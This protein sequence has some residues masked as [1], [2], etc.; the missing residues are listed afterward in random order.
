VS[1][2][3]VVTVASYSGSSGTPSL[4]AWRTVGDVSI[5]TTVR[6]SMEFDFTLPANGV[7]RL[8][9]EV[10]SPV[11][12]TPY[13]VF[14]IEVWIDGQFIDRVDLLL[15]YGG[16]GLVRVITPWLAQGTH[17][18]R[19]VYDNTLSYRPIQINALRIQEIGGP[20]ADD[21]GRADWIDARLAADNSLA[22]GSGSGFVSPAFVEGVSRFFDSLAIE[23]DGQPAVAARS[24]GLGWFADVPLVPG[25]LVNLRASFENGALQE[26]RSLRWKPFNLLV[27]PSALPAGRLR[28]RMNDTLL[29]TATPDEASVMESAADPTESATVVISRAGQ[30]DETFILDRPSTAPQAHVF[31]APGIYTITGTHVSTQGGGSTLTGTVEVEVVAAAFSGDPV[32][33]LAN[34]IVWDNPLLPQ[35]VTIEHDQGVELAELPVVTGSS[36]RLLTR[37]LGVSRVVARLHPGG[38]ILDQALVTGLRVVSDNHTAID[39]LQ[40]YPDGSRL[41]GTPIMLS[42]I[43]PDTR[44]E[45]EIFVN[46]VTFEDGTTLKVF[47]A[48][49]FDE[50]GRVYVKFVYPAGLGSSFCHRIHVYRGEKYLGTF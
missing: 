10:F 38:P 4:G 8:E 34:P 23:L 42:E 3:H 9:F 17:R 47:T 1:D 25:G 31:S 32:A 41:I 7:R 22:A 35:D 21:N 45:V 24:P 15:P 28:I 43:T 49:D 6:A 33:G 20:D 26:T 36:F 37:N 50:Y 40:A 30:S 19:F 18:V 44:I 39:V 48:D 13:A 12:Q 11:N 29:L 14:P 5:S 27:D 46:G 2:A 16:A